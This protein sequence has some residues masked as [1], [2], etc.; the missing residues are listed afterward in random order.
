MVEV[1]RGPEQESSLPIGVLVRGGRVRLDTRSSLDHLRR[2]TDS[3]GLLFQVRNLS[4]LI[5]AGASIHIGG[6]IIRALDADALARFVDIHG[7]EFDDVEL[8]AAKA[9][10][11]ESIDLERALAI[12]SSAVAFASETKTEVVRLGVDEYS[13]ATLLA[14][15]RKINHALANACNIPAHGDFVALS[16]HRSFLSR[17]IR[18]R[19]PDLPRARLF[20][21]N[22]DLAIER[23]LDELGIQ[24]FDGFAGTIE[25]VLRPET[26]G[27]ELYPTP[28][29]GLPRQ[30]VGAT[31]SVY[32]L[33]GS[34]NWRVRTEADEL[35]TTVV[36]QSSDPLSDVD[37]AVIYPTPE[38]ESETVG[39]PYSDMFRHFGTAISEPET[40]LLVTGYSFSD[41]HVNRQIQHALYGNPS[42]HLF[43]A[44]PY[45]VF[46]DQATGR[47]VPET[48][49]FKED[50]QIAGLA[51]IR[52]A[53]VSVL[54]GP[55]AT[56]EN[57]ATIALPL[58]DEPTATGGDDS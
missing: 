31:A 46:V 50:S 3:L 38:K 6:P 49:D 47:D 36:Y 35:G 24:Y 17:L 53:R 39:Y 1:S 8:L 13:L 9:V 37:L 33:H 15:R 42:L 22:Y 41:A 58:G 19:R 2:I 55:L 18:A 28:L 54:T 34:I 4:V 51:R 52:D 57:L 48:Y 40:A 44:S 43:I 16:I 10:A 5:G 25:R 20:T 7:D 11:A 21:T 14:V 27:Y 45:D 56:F 23:G 30:R 29:A 12:L 32:K 26:F